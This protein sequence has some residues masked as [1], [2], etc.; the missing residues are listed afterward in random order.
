MK[1]G[2][3]VAT[4]LMVLGSASAASAGSLEVRMGGFMPRAESNLFDDDA[5]L[6]GTEKSDFGGLTGGIEFRGRVSENFEAGIHLDGYGKSV[7]TSYREF[8]RESGREITQTLKFQV[9]PLG[10][11]LKWLPADRD[12]TIQPYVGGGVDVVFWQYEEFGDFIDFDD[13]DL[14][15]IEDAFISDGATVGA[16][17][18]GG[19][20]FRIN[21]DFGLSAEAKF[22]GAGTPEMNKDFIGNKVDVSGASFTIGG[23]IN[24]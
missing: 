20:R 11:S 22:L 17:L 4:V 21:H 7:H 9:V 15:I 16:H 8:E 13:A 24:F 1:T 23:Y 6:Y 3:A 12:A 18:V 10:V 2:F 14:P 19:L 5:D